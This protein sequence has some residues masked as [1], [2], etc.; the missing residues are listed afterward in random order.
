MSMKI[1]FSD[2]ADVPQIFADGCTRVS[3]HE[4]IV[5]IELVSTWVSGEPN[6]LVGTQIPQVHLA[7]TPTAAMALLGQLSGLVDMLERHG[8]VKRV[9]NEPQAPSGASSH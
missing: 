6:E 1:V 4:G 7:I 2:K 9:Q 3:F 8:V 5:Q